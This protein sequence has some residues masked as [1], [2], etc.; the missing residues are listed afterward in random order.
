MQLTCRDCGPRPECEFKEIAQIP[1]GVPEA[2]PARLMEHRERYCRL[3][4]W[5]VAPVKE[6]TNG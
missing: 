5:C 1:P 4:R 2:Q 6:E 3:R